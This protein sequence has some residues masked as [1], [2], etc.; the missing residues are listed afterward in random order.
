MNI[1]EYITVSEYAREN[2]LDTS[3][4]RHKIARG[5]FPAIK[6]GNQWLIRKD[7]KWTDNRRIKKEAE[8]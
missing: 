5:L 2:N 1:N 4:I 3:T 8:R 7:E 6:V